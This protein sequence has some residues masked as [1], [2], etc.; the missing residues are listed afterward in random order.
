MTKF[1]YFMR[2]ICN[3]L[4]ESDIIAIS[5]SEDGGPIRQQAQPEPS[6]S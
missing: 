4:F 5:K 1:F 2:Y 3:T 6:H